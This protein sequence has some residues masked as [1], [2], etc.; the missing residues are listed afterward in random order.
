MRNVAAYKDLE[1]VTSA[2]AI[3]CKSIAG[4]TIG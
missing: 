1:M 3:T 4:G 2:G